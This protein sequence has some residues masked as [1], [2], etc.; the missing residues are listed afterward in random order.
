VRRMTTAK[1]IES[2]ETLVA[3]TPLLEAA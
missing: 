3:P 1:A 2:S